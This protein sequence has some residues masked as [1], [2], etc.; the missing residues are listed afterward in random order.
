LFAVTGYEL[1]LDPAFGTVRKQILECDERKVLSFTSEFLGDIPLTT[2]RILQV[3][4]P[5]WHRGWAVQFGRYFVH[6][7]ALGDL[8]FYDRMAVHA[9]EPITMYTYKHMGWPNEPSFGLSNGIAQL[10]E[11]GTNPK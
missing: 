6:F 1:A 3:L 9:S 4:A 2:R 10:R 8:S 11:F 7:P 5:E